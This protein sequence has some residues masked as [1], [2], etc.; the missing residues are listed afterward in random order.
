[1]R[2]KESTLDDLLS[3]LMKF[4]WWGG[5][6]LAGAVYVAMRYVIPGLVFPDKPGEPMADIRKIPLSSL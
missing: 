4:P 1:M 3:L 2:R 5:P 6:V